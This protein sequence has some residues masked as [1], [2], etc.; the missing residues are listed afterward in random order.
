MTS[1][2]ASAVV[3]RYFGGRGIPITCVNFDAKYI[4]IRFRAGMCLFS[5]TETKHLDPIT[6]ENR[7]NIG[8]VIPKWVLIIVAL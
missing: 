3:C 4:Q 2:T 1:R 6:S 7:F 5:V 8:H